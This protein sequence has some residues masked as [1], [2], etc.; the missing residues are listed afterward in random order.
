MNTKYLEALACP[1][2]KGPLKFFAA[3]NS[4][5]CEAESLAYP[6]KDGIMY[7]EAAHR[8]AWDAASQ[9]AST[10]QAAS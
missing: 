4:L 7:L 9:S 5:V 8:L 6:V 10:E 3:A 1:Q 2:C